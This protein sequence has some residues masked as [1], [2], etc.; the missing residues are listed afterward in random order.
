MLF[1]RSSSP[2]P[3][4][5]L[6]TLLI[7]Y[8]SWIRARLFHRFVP[9]GKALQSRMPF[10]TLPPSFTWPIPTRS[11]RHSSYSASSLDLP[12][13]LRQRCLPLLLFPRHSVH[14]LILALSSLHCKPPV[15]CEFQ[16]DRDVAYPSLLCVPSSQCPGDTEQS[17][18]TVD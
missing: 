4:I 3:L 13:L 18:K 15:Y 12:W 2:S 14:T 1:S 5:C 10:P 16:E 8:H 11:S 7:F 17:V 6:K 9:L